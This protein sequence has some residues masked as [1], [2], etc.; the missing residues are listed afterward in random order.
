[1]KLLAVRPITA[2]GFDQVFEKLKSRLDQEH[3]LKL[4]HLTPLSQETLRDLEDILETNFVEVPG[5]YLVLFR[6]FGNSR[7]GKLE[8]AGVKA[9]K[10][11]QPKEKTQKEEKPAKKKAVRSAK[12]AA[13]PKSKKL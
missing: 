6:R 8:L 13:K 7:S 11:R 9:T 2:R 4:Q 5:S 12:T 10:I 1:M 3:G